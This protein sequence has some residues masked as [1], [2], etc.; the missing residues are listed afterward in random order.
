MKAVP[1]QVIVVLDEAYLEYVDA[2]DYPSALDY[3]EMRDRV[4]VTRTFSNAMA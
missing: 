2:P 4:M 3:L 1:E